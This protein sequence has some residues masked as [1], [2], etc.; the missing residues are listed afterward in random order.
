MKYLWISLTC[1]AALITGVFLG[2]YH[3]APFAGKAAAGS[4]SRP[5]GPKAHAN[6]TPDLVTQL[7]QTSSQRK[8]TAVILNALAN[9]GSGGMRQL[10]EAAGKDFNELSLL[11]EIARHINPAE[12]TKE[13]ARE[14]SHDD[15]RD[16]LAFDF[17]RDWAKTDFATAFRTCSALPSFSGRWLGGA[18]LETQFATDPTTVLKMAVAN[19]ELRLSWGN[20]NKIPATPEN[21]DLVRALPPSM[22]KFGLIENLATDLPPDQAYA[23]ILEDRNSNPGFGL[24]RIAQAMMQK[25]PQAAQEWLAAHPDHPA[26]TF[27]SRRI[28]DHLI[29]TAPAEAVEWITSQLS[30]IRRT[31]A[32]ERAAAALQKTDP[33]AAEAARNLLPGSF[34]TK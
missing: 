29:N 9:G 10:V 23:L 12:F 3:A 24:P 5:G 21:V 28:A 4:A 17:V 25:D 2:R 13:L 16:Q 31:K 1:A 15:F 26:A 8:K 33:A 20:E 7:K 19:P 32:L 22:G 11:A 14:L 18:V 6:P 34:K 27:L 30:G